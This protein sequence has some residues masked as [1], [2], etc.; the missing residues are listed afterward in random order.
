MINQFILTPLFLDEPL[1]G[2]ETIA[3]PDWIINKPTLLNGDKQTRITAVNRELANV[4]AETISA[5][6][7]P[8][9]IAG[10]CLS[11]IGVLTGLQRAGVNPF[12]VWFDAHGD[13]NTW[14]TSPSG[15]LGGMPLAMIV[16]RGDQRI[17]RGV[18]LT[19]FLESRVLLMDARD[20]DPEE[21]ISLRRSAVIHCPHPDRV[22]G[23]GFPD[24]SLYIH[25]DTDI[26][27]P[28]EAPAQNYP[29]PGGLSVIELKNVFRRL[30]M[31]AHIVAVS[32]SSWNPE[33]DPSR[34]SEKASLDA[35]D[36][37]I[38]SE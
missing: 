36:A 7:R 21:R 31:K 9:S 18:G 29:A 15:F 19:P 10:D 16:G 20:L 37:L 23:P 28:A 27:D 22:A 12:L 30:A 35:L 33:L 32:V 6:K 11:A 24:S 38:G 26:I 8:V 2:L 5:G 4:V 1:P 17:P 34:M 14:E 3:E 25:V 13:F